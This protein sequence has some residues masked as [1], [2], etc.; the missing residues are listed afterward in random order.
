[1][2]RKIA[3]AAACLGFTAV[4]LGAV[5]AHMLPKPL[6]PKYVEVWRMAA[7]YHGL[8]ALALL[9][10]AAWRTD[11]RW[12]AWAARAWVVGVVIFSGSLY[13]LVLA[14]AGFG[15]APAPVWPPVGGLLLMAGWLLAGV[16]AWREK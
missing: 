14:R 12:V 3:L 7:H 6:D 8:H 10:L 13:L 16:A 5:G 9:A 11:S 2:N 4:L 15:R 1:M